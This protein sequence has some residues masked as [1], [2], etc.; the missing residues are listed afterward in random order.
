MFI[1]FRTIGKSSGHN[2]EYRMARL[3]GT[4]PRASRD[5]SHFFPETGASSTARCSPSRVDAFPHR[6]DFSFF[7]RFC[8]F[9]SFFLS[10]S[11]DNHLSL[12]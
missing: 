8:D 12:M 6:P 5:L 10:F 7:H 2:D 4:I 9:L 3:A 11:L 1:E